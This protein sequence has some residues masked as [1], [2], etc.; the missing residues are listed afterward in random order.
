MIRYRHEL[1]Y[2]VLQ[3]ASL[4]IILSKERRTRWLNSLECADV[5]AGMHIC[6]FHARRL[7]F[8]MT[9]P[10]CVGYLIR[11]RLM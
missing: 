11:S 9:R 3:V 4:T 2:E 7:G 10:V 8:P 6:C 5:Q 1:E